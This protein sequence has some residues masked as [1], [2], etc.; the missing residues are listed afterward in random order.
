MGQLG[1]VRYLG[2][3]LGANVNQAMHN[4]FTPL[5]IAAI[6]GYV[7]VVR[8]L[9]NEFGANVSQANED[10]ATSLMFAAKQ[11]DLNMVRCLGKE[12]GANVNQANLGGA[13]SLLIASKSGHL[14]VVRYLVIL[15][16]DIKKADNED[17]TLLMAA[18]MEE[19]TRVV[20]WLTK[21]LNAIN[22]AAIIKAAKSYDIPELRRLGDQGLRTTTAKPLY[23]AVAGGHLD[24][25]RVLIEELGADVNQPDELGGIPIIWPPRSREVSV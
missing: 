17:I 11:G 18:Y 24:M 20:A 4:G 15:G 14:N 19:H 9:G 3:E 7:D 16:A 5:I 8:C 2:K 25:V 22:E 23:I 13:T 1:V 12:L 21:E 6:H 10:G